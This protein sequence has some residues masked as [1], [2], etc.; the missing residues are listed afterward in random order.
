MARAGNPRPRY[1]AALQSRG[2]NGQVLAQFVVD[3]TGHADPSTFEVVQSSDKSFSEA[4]KDVLPRMRFFP[5]EVGGR[6]VKQLV[7]QSFLF[8]AAK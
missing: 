1:P 4:V 3:T 6:K 2:I 8:V 5:A 7:E